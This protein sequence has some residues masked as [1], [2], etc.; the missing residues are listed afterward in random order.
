MWDG[1]VEAV[2]EKGGVGVFKEGV[3][4][5]VS[6]DVAQVLPGLEVGAGLEV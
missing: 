6:D 5:G 2:W 3:A 1:V 4:V